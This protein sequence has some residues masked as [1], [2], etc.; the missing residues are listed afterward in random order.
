MINELIKLATHLDEKGLSKEADYLDAIIKQATTHP[1]KEKPETHPRHFEDAAFPGKQGARARKKL[2]RNIL[3]FQGKAAL[4]EVE[5][6]REPRIWLPTIEKALS[7][8]LPEWSQQE[9]TD[10]V[11]EYMAYL[12]IT[13]GAYEPTQWSTRAMQPELSVN[14]VI[15]IFKHWRDERYID[16]EQYTSL[17]LGVSWAKV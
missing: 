12:G 11:R 7:D 8:E 14:S 16:D 4:D 15:L 5:L 9:A 3:I 2:R 17:T 10:D 13:E 6:K 1:S